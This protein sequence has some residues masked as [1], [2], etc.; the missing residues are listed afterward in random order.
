VPASDSARASELAAVLAGWL[1]RLMPDEPRRERLLAALADRFDADARPVDGDVGA[2][3]QALARRFSRHLDLEWVPE[4]VHVSDVVYR[5]GLR[6]WESLPQPGLPPGTPAAAL[7]GPRT[8]S[9]GEAFAL[10]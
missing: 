2:E 6:R 5:D 3:M 1:A 8:Y 9:S 7:I 10:L 4:P